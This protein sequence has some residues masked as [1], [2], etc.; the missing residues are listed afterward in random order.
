MLDCA[1]YARDFQVACVVGTVD[2]F[3]GQQAPIVFFLSQLP[4]ARTC[5]AISRFFFRAIA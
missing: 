3:Q 1:D 5:R 2:K 4:A